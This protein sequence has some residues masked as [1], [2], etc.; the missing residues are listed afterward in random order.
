MQ[1]QAEH[2]FVPFGDTLAV[3]TSDRG[4]FTGYGNLK[5]YLE[6]NYGSIFDYSTPDVY[7]YAVLLK[8]G[9]A[10][11]THGAADGF[12]YTVDN[13][14]GYFTDAK[15]DKRG[16]FLNGKFHSTTDA[17]SA[18]VKIKERQDDGLTM[19]MSIGFFTLKSFRVYPK[20]YA[21]ELPKY[22]APEFLQQG[23]ED[24]R[25]WGSILIRQKVQVF[26]CSI[27]PMPAMAPAMITNVLS[28]KEP[29][30]KTEFLSKYL[31]DVD[32]QL[33]LGQVS[34][35]INA[36]YWGVAYEVFCNE[37]IPIEDREA[38][39]NGALQEFAEYN[40]K[41][42]QQ[43]KES[44]MA[45]AEEMSKILHSQFCDPKTFTPLAGMFMKEHGEAVLAAVNTYL[46]RQY[47]LAEANGKKKQ[48]LSGKAIS[49]ANHKTLREMSDALGSHCDGMMECKGALD[50]FL[51]AYDPEAETESAKR[52][53]EAR[54][55]RAK[56]LRNRVQ[57]TQTVN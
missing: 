32:E 23:L 20:D 49:K 35:L 19:G 50:E 10:P 21:T 56:I 51:D 31:G 1:K 45:E 43:F 36:L 5:G 6:N 3:D 41:I 28:Q 24:A 29:I 7:D 8:N 15:E 54:L 18:R 40:A 42:F 25:N 22:L 37:N 52:L 2:L 13:L 14:L 12:E 26:E 11:D 33:S 53:E 27:T 39:W 47:S 44:D 46:A 16:L 48:T 30:M 55:L 57:L 4:S 38:M 17:Q 34:T 9:F